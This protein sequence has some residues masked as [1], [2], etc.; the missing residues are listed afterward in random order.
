MSCCNCGKNRV[1]TK[2]EKNKDKQKASEIEEKSLITTTVISPDTFSMIKNDANCNGIKIEDYYFRRPIKNKYSKNE[3]YS[4]KVK[5]IYLGI[6]P[7]IYK[8]YKENKFEPSFHPF[9]ILD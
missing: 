2:E 6:H 9:F 5:E 4:M 8:N 3:L 7:T 1:A